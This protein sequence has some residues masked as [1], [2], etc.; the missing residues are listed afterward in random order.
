MILKVYVIYDKVSEQVQTQLMTA[1]K[2]ELMI[3][4]LKTAKLGDLIETNL[5]DFDLIQVGEI[6]TVKPHLVGLENGKFIC[7]LEAIK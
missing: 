6:D 7:H 2:D 3:R 4:A 5:E 1:E